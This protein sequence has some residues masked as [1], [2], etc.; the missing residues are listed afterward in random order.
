MPTLTALPNEVLHQILLYFEHDPPTLLSLS[1]LTHNLHALARPHLYRHLALFVSTRSDPISAQYELLMRTLTHAPSPAPLVRH[2][3]LSVHKGV[4]ESH[5]RANA[6]LRLLPNLTTLRISAGRGRADFKPTF[7]ASNP[8]PALTELV[9]DDPQL[10]VPVL[11]SWLALPALRALT[12]TLLFFPSHP[13][14][15]PPPP[16]TPS[17]LLS[18]NL[19][20][21]H[22]PPHLL[23]ALL[24]HTPH[25][26]SLS[27]AFPGPTP[28]RVAHN[29]P[30]ALHPSAIAAALQPVQ[31]SLRALHMGSGVLP[32]A[33]AHDGSRLDLS[34]WPELRLVN[35]P[36]GVLFTTAG[37]ARTGRDGIGALLPPALEVLQIDFDFG[38]GVLY[39]DDGW[40]AFRAAG[41]GAVE[42]WKWAWLLEVARGKRGGRWPGLR[43]V[44]LEERIKQPRGFRYDRVVWQPPLDLLRAFEEV[45][46]ELVVWLRGPLPGR[47]R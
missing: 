45:G 26:T 17:P 32:P 15:T 5:A 46:V 7:L 28:P 12:L 31:N 36:A 38:W 24:A 1:L 33:T 37:P 39:L 47:V 16:S 3:V 34:A 20:T 40:G 14:P 11:L 41:H 18:L 43:A 27:L 21:R 29:H 4:A 13:S 8:L 6:L 22:I 23:S 30:S 9:L 42:R 25:L 10:T 44:R 2:L 19:G 35:V